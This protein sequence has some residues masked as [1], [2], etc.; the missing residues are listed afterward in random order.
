[1]I[2]RCPNTEQEC[3]INIVPQPKTGFLIISNDENKSEIRKH[4]GDLFEKQNFTLIDAMSNK[5]TGN[6]YCKICS[7]ILSCPFGVALITKNTKKTALRNIFLEIGLLTAFGKELIIL[8]DNKRNILSDFAGLE[9][10]IFKDDEDLQKQINDWLENQIPA[11]IYM[12][13]GLAADL[14]DNADYEGSYMNYQR[15]ILFGDY[16]NALPKFIEKF[17]SSLNLDKDIETNPFVS[18]R[19]LRDIQTLVKTGKI[20]QKPI[21]IKNKEKRNVETVKDKKRIGIKNFIEN[22]EIPSIS[23]NSNDV[24]KGWFA[25]RPNYQNDYWDYTASFVDGIQKSDVPILKSVIYWYESISEAITAFKNAKSDDSTKHRLLFSVVGD[26]SYGY[27]SW[28]P[29]AVVVFR[30][31]NILARIEFRCNISNVSIEDAEKYATVVDNK[32]RLR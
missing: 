32:I 14:F 2:V 22:E 20:I 11:N 18:K 8:T 15:A 9:W 25:E 31:G 29:L 24:P 10:F 30:R 6:F 3:N 26:Q 12:W 7:M 27:I 16:F 23:L 21:Q 4:I 17:G 5:K 13:T 28:Y 1:M 19:F